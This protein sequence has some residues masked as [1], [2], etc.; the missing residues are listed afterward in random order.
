M[1][2]VPSVL[3][4]AYAL[5]ATLKTTFLRM[6]KEFVMNVLKLNSVMTPP[7]NVLPVMN[8]VLPVPIL[9]IAKAVTN[10]AVSL[11]MN[12][13]AKLALPTRS[14]NQT[15]AIVAQTTTR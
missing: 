5:S 4:L 15:N 2:N 7:T 9:L 11:I 3:I 10:V 13:F 12:K 8:T 14:V 1:L 6:V